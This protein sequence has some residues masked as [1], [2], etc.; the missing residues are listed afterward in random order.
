[1]DGWMDGWMDG[2][3]VIKMLPSF[4]IRPCPMGFDNSFEES[5]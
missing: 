4:A 3:L 5:F 1:M 2:A